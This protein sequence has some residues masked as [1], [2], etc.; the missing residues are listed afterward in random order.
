MV[1]ALTDAA[2]DVIVATGALDE[3]T[4]RTL[5]AIAP[6]VT[7]PARAGKWAWQDQLTW[8]GRLLGR[9]DAAEE[10][11]SASADRQ[12]D[13]RVRHPAFSG[14]TVEV[15][16]VSD[17][18]VTAELSDSAAAQYLTDLGFVYRDGLQ[19]GTA[20]PPGAR[21]VSDPA[22]LNT[23][24]VEVRIVVRTDSAA[25]GGGYNGLPAAFTRYR[26]VTMIVDD[27]GVISALE[28]G[29]YA[30]TSF[31]DEQLVPAIGRQVH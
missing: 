24:P 4:Y 27:P 31:L 15:L 30:A 5:A 17:D 10:L 28:V 3:Q 21:P 6:T 11:I 16:N 23:D 29:G 9:Q 13:I 8:I 26:G 12:S 1:T 7:R 20:D 14:K 25:G 22:V 18:G 19:R 2:P